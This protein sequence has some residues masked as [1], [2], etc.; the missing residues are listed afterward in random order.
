MCHGGGGGRWRGWSVG[1]AVAV[2]VEL[3]APSLRPAA[4]RIALPWEPWAPGPHDGFQAARRSPST[5][6]NQPSSWFQLTKMRLT[7][8]NVLISL[9]RNLDPQIGNRTARRRSSSPGAAETDSSVSSCE[10]CAL[11]G[12]VN[13]QHGGMRRTTS[14]AV[15]GADAILAQAAR[16]TASRRLSHSPSA[17]SSFDR[18]I[19]RLPFLSKRGAVFQQPDRIVDWR[20]AQMRVSLRRWASR[21]E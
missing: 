2:V 7:S 5:C 10:E 18:G 6:R 1:V 16:R 8:S 20:R 9:G 17:H 21:S 11:P 19:L 3:L 4:G 15:R 14:Q 13:E 12:G